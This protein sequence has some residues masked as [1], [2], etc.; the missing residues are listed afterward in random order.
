MMRHGAAIAQMDAFVGNQIIMPPGSKDGEV[1]MMV[2][3]TVAAPHAIMVDQTGVRYQNEGGDYAAF[4]QGMLARDKTVPAVPSWAVFDSQFMRD[5]L[6]AMESNAAR[7]KAWVR[8][9]F[10]RSA[11]T[12]DGLAQ[13]LEMDPAALRAT[14]D[15]FNGFV[16]K[17]KDEDF[18]RGDRFY[19]QWLGN[20]HH[21]PS[22]TLGTIDAGPFYAVAVYPGDVGTYGGVVTDDRARVLREDGSVIPGLYATATSTAS[23]M[24]R[25]CPGA[26]ASV[27]PGFVWGYVAARH[28]AN[29]DNAQ[30]ASAVP[31]ASRD[32][33]SV[34]G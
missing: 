14:V 15:R 20:L 29:L 5:S 33:A 34:P 13:K 25:V 23:V 8:D 3:G 11:D 2:Q 27:G 30:T 19:D 10:V 1:R 26:G 21:K 32:P 28:A 7:I 17:N 12:L 22:G 24:G 31:A 16:A 18:H 9:G 4:C 6:L